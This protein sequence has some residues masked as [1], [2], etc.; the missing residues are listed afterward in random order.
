MQVVDR[1]RR[2]P[3][4]LVLAGLPELCSHFRGTGTYLER[5]ESHELGYLG[6]D[7]ARLAL[8]QPASERAVTFEPRAIEMLAE[9]SEGYPYAVQLLGYEAWEAADGAKVITEA[10]AKR[11]VR[12]T[13]RRMAALYENRWSGVSDREREYLV[14]VAVLGPGSVRSTD[15]AEQLGAT[16]KSLSPR[17]QKLL[18]LRLLKS[19]EWGEIEF[20]LPGMSAWILAKT[21]K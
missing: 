6:E 15:V 2:L 10:H 17:R 13:V 20:A 19:S 18:E 21:G 5:L 1:R 8:L 16:V 12:Q 14:A 11:A 4:A 9:V 7:A 3:V